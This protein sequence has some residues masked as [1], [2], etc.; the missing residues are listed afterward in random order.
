MIVHKFGVKID[1]NN[2]N[3]NHLYT[4]VLSD[5]LIHKI[6]VNFKL[7]EIKKILEIIKDSSI[8]KEGFVE[9]IEYDLLTKNPILNGK[10]DEIKEFFC[11]PTDFIKS[12]T[13]LGKNIIKKAYLKWLEY[14]SIYHE[15]NDLIKFKIQPDID[16]TK[17]ID[18]NYYLEE[19]EK[20]GL[21]E[22]LLDILEF[23]IV[24]SIEKNKLEELQQYQENGF[25]S[26]NKQIESAN[27]YL[28]YGRKN[29]EL[30]KKIKIN[31]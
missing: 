7:E 17:D 27:K 2:M 5:N 24:A 3:N 8:L 11:N 10:Y 23:S 25:I 30:I 26:M 29:Y 18:L 31:L 9:N 1:T 13:L 14:P 22:E 15:L 21:K 12:E 28:E 4:Y 16:K 20:F 19:L 6:E